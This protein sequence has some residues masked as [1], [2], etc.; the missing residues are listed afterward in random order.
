MGQADF[1]HLNRDGR[2]LGWRFSNVTVDGDGRATLTPLAA[3]PGVAV[4]AGEAPAPAGVL[5]SGSG[6]LWWSSPA[7]GTL[8]RIG[9]CGDDDTACAGPELVEPRGLAAARERGLVWLADPGLSRVLLLR[10]DGSLVQA[11]GAPG[12]PGGPDAPPGTL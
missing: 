8:C 4:P 1:R 10:S 7:T 3:G 9:P 5:K 11:I 12:A 6:A 2:W